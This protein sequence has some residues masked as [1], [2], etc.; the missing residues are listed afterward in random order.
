M[1]SLL[2]KYHGK[3]ADVV[4]RLVQKYNEQSP[5]ELQAVLQLTQQ[6]QQAPHQEPFGGSSFGMGGGIFGTHQ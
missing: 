1:D 4:T 6:Q 5:Q 3:E 2:A